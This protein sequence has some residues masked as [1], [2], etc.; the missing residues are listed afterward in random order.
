MKRLLPLLLLLI[1]PLVLAEAGVYRVEVIIFRH[2]NTTEVPATVDELRSFSQF[3]TLV[4]DL[5][6][7]IQIPELLAIPGADPSADG[8]DNESESDPDGL[9]DDSEDD[10]EAAFPGWP[11]NDLPDDLQIF[12]KLSGRM[13]RVWRRLRSSVSYRPLVYAIWEQNRTDYYPPIRIHDEQVIDTQLR[14]PTQI[15]IADLTNYAPLVAY[16]SVFYR[17]DGSV[18]LRR[19]RFLH[20]FVDLV[21]RDETET[22]ATGLSIDGAVSI[23]D[24]T[25]NKPQYSV[26]SL[27]Q[28]RQIST[29]KLQYFDTPFFGALIFVTTLASQSANTETP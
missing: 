22:L 11:V 28:N 10:S 15:M 9:P 6:I 2:L 16:R 1:S 14:P 25:L 3:P 12:S 21:Y 27:R 23:E 5:P 20:L 29:G 7:E 8:D 24:L 18:Q 4:K 17:L 19:S 26:F 13:D